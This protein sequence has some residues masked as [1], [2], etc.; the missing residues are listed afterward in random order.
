MNKYK[1][2]FEVSDNYNNGGFRNFVKYLLSDSKYEVFIISNDDSSTYINA[3][4]QVL[5]IPTDHVKICNFSD[6]K[7]NQISVNDIDIHFDNLQSFVILVDN[8]TN[9]YGILVS[10]AENKFNSEPQYMTD[11]NQILKQIDRDN[12]EIS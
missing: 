8:T 12:E 4:A 10:S 9:A 3:I 2:S 1:I 7:L 5:N 11:F 6:D